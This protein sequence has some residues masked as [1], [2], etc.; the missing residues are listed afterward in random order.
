MR[1]LIRKPFRLVV[2]C[3]IW[4]LNATSKAVLEKGHYG[5]LGQLQFKRLPISGRQ[6]GFGRGATW[7][8]TCHLFNDSPP[9]NPVALIMDH[10]RHCFAVSNVF[11]FSGGS[12]KAAADFE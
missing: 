1:F 4:V 5:F 2:Y 7:E 3:D 6:Y 8:G 12:K 11:V 10:I 9:Q